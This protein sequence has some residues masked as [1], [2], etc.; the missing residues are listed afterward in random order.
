MFAVLVCN[1]IH[2]NGNVKFQF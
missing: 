2:V 1:N